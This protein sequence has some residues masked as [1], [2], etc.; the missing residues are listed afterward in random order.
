MSFSDKDFADDAKIQLRRVKSFSS[1]DRLQSMWERQRMKMEREIEDRLSKEYEVRKKSLDR[2]ATKLKQ[3]Q[4]NL[5]KDRRELNRLKQQVQTEKRIIFQT[6]KKN[7][8]N[9][10]PSKMVD[11]LKNLIAE[12]VLAKV[13]ATTEWENVRNFR[14]LEER[15]IQTKKESLKNEQSA[16]TEI[17]AQLDSEKEL[18]KQQKA[19]Y[20]LD[21]EEIEKKRKDLIE[22]EEAYELEVKRLT[23]WEESIREEQDNVKKKHKECARKMEMLKTQELENARFKQD[24]LSKT[25]A[26]A[27]LQ[28]ELQGKEL[29]LKDIQADVNKDVTALQEERKMWDKEQ[30]QIYFDQMFAEKREELEREKDLFEKD[31]RDLELKKK[32]EEVMQMDLIRKLQDIE[33]EEKTLQGM[34]VEVSEQLIILDAKQT[35]ISRKEKEVEKMRNNMVAAL[36]IQ[37]KN[38]KKIKIQQDEIKNEHRKL[39]AWLEK[40][41][42]E[43]MAEEIAAIDE[44]RNKLEEESD[45]F[46]LEKEEFFTRQR[47]LL[48]GEREVL[49]LKNEAQLA[50]LDIIKSRAILEKDQK[51]VKEKKL[52]VQKHQLHLEK[53]S[54]QLESDRESMKAKVEK[55]LLEKYNAMIKLAEKNSAA[56]A[57]SQ[58]D[59]H[60]QQL[61]LE[62]RRGNLES[63]INE[64]VKSLVTQ[65]EKVL[66]RRE[67]KFEIEMGRLNE[68]R[69]S[70]QRAEREAK[71]LKSESQEQME[72]ANKKLAQ[73]AKQWDIIQ[74]E[75]EK[76]LEERKKLSEELEK[77]RRK[78]IEENE[79]KNKNGWLG[80]KKRRRKSE[81][82]N[83]RLAGEN[84]LAKENQKDDEFF[85]NK[86]NEN[87][88]GGKDMESDE[89]ELTQE[90]K[91]GTSH[92]DPFS[93]GGS[94]LK[95]NIMDISTDEMLA[96]KKSNRHLEY[97]LVAL[98]KKLQQARED[99]TNTKN[100]VKDDRV[101]EWSH[102]DSEMPTLFMALQE[103]SDKSSPETVN[104]LK[105]ELGG[106]KWF[107]EKVE[108]ISPLPD[109][110]I[111]KSHTSGST[112]IFRK[113]S[114]VWRRRSSTRDSISMSEILLIKQGFSLES[115]KSEPLP[116]VLERTNSRPGKHPRRPLSD[117]NIPV[118]CSEDL[119]ISRRPSQVTGK[120]T[121]SDV[122]T[123]T[124]LRKIDLV[125][126]QTPISFLIGEKKK[127]IKTM[128]EV[129]MNVS[130]R[131]NM[132]VSRNDTLDF[133]DL[134]VEGFDAML[135]FVYTNT[136]SFS[137]TSVVPT[138][139]C[140]CEFL[141]YDLQQCCF[142]WL[143]T[144]FVW[145]WAN[146]ILDDCD[147]HAEILGY[148]TKEK[149]EKLIW[150]LTISDDTNNQNAFG[151][152]LESR[153]LKWVKS[154]LKSKNLISDEETLFV[155][156]THWACYQAR[157]ECPNVIDI[158]P[159]NWQT[160]EDEKC[161]P[162]TIEAK[163]HVVKLLNELVPFIRF[164]IMA[165][166][167]VSGNQ[168]IRSLLKAV[169]ND[170][171]LPEFNHTPRWVIQEVSKEGCCT[172]SSE[173]FA[174]L[175]RSADQA[176]LLTPLS[177]INCSF[178]MPSTNMGRVLAA[179]MAIS[180]RRTG[181][182]MEDS[183][184]NVAQTKL[185]YQPWWEI[186]LGRVCRIQKLKVILGSATAA[187]ENEKEDKDEKNEMFPLT[188][189]LAREAFPDMEGTLRQSMKMS[190]IT[191]TFEKPPQNEYNILE[192]EPGL[193]AARTFR[194]QCK[195][196][197]SLKVVQV[198]IFSAEP[199]DCSMTP[200][201]GC[202]K[203][204]TPSAMPH[205]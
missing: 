22:T 19:K 111:M 190:I 35:E 65:K 177:D 176:Q 102:I 42:R 157:L 7:G 80:F 105:V 61:E 49:R 12:S 165:T 25:N 56:L 29:E 73:A 37:Q 192:W 110:V 146:Q 39:S 150:D 187:G 152:V 85:E 84:N 11:E 179:H 71:K 180:T 189:C 204:I 58:E 18:L 62:R 133:P 175:S 14:R 40:K 130:E 155:A 183:W 52:K 69:R 113:E 47:N 93:M 27:I 178:K 17:L 162:Q 126:E 50:K 99:M 76:F 94:K 123:S 109:S 89:E 13:K 151:R 31:K 21:V 148:D 54:R 191:K 51:A 167:Y 184:L 118:F 116:S 34:K 131:M 174:I 63:E 81:K 91:P 43:E 182:S 67:K 104:D 129:M 171:R 60:K 79:K 198:K 33:N 66:E 30:K 120:Q 119:D 53:L 127:V 108:E 107:V 68:E 83:E 77:D 75:K 144:N 202:P 5:D 100:V 20:S 143:E 166:E 9:K 23:S 168:L 203:I 132:Y 72:Q 6:V 64:R 44:Q 122:Y 169:K 48:D 160:I 90:E 59:Q 188:F 170:P 115:K 141:Y 88:L 194:L 161:S 124:S 41:V 197:T 4:R 205:F 82:L 1:Q 135:N 96:L 201:I 86:S 26:C 138:L 38:E 103:V 46:I 147:R 200:K 92:I 10:S 186:D 199:E 112:P 15:A 145:S 195:K 2:E 32:Q 36:S 196:T 95:H 101:L 78:L 158:L 16:F 164:R 106:D 87:K 185:D 154:V 57:Q 121:S 125:D 139:A 156:V 70:L 159:K 8:K 134:T 153:D 98:Q 172:Q 181:Q 55:E 140:A 173:H 142:D 137:K 114:N 3:G 117:S 128:K 136:C 163:K 149:V 97:Q 45:E 24:L 28:L 193:I 74:Y